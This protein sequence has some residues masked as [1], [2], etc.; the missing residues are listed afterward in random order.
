MISQSWFRLLLTFSVIILCSCTK[1]SSLKY[2]E[3]IDAF[4]S[5]KWCLA[6]PYIIYPYKKTYGQH[7][8]SY[9]GLFK[10]KNYSDQK[11]RIKNA[12]GLTE[13]DFKIIVE[14]S[15]INFVDVIEEDADFS[16]TF[17]Y[18][19]AQIDKEKIIIA[20]SEILNKQ[21]NIYEDN[22]SN[23]IK[24]NSIYQCGN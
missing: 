2:E 23:F 19:V 13:E 12:Y 24:T 10:L 18:F 7:N 8:F 1:R 9:G 16:G 20:V 4:L 5:K 6:T 15:L 14:G 21:S 3:N 11:I 17:V 22:L